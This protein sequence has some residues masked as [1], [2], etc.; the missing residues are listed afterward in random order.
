MFP[1]ISSSLAA[2]PPAWQ[3]TARL[4]L[5]RMDGFERMIQSRESRVCFGRQLSGNS[6]IPLHVGMS[7]WAE[8]GIDCGMLVL[9]IN[10]IQA[11]AGYSVEYGWEDNDGNEPLGRGALTLA[12]LPNTRLG[13]ETIAS[14]LSSFVERTDEG[15]LAILRK[16]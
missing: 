8:A 10:V 12:E 1:H 7:V 6:A 4:L 15:L 3:D 2:L 9:F 11:E 13:Q 14:S 5:E 16:W